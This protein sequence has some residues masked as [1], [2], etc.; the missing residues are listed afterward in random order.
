MSVRFVK[1]LCAWVCVAL[2]SGLAGCSTIRIA[3][4]QADHVVA[5]MVDDYFDLN[6]EQEHAF[7][8]QFE[9]LH[10]WHRS[11]QLP[12][13]AALLD[14]VRQRLQA[15]ASASDAEWFMDALKARYRVLVLHAY[16]D[17]ARL[18]STLSDEQLEAAR[19]HFEKVNRKYTKEQGVGASADEQRRVRAR[20]HVERIEHWTGPLDSVQEARVRELSRALP[21]MVEETY[22]E[23]VRRQAEFLALLQERRSSATFAPRL[24]DW[25][26]DW[27]RTRSPQYQAQYA[28]F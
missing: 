14:A 6:G 12:D 16:A 8:A 24:R 2:L 19:R 15:G 11:T 26:L 20:R 13:Y 18:L 17:A 1:T 21:L 23:R 25:L 5:W 10:A 22:R 28:Q 9:G 7:R 27:D 4:N 3:Y